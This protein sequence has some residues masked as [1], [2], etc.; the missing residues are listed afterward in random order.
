MPAKK[1]RSNGRATPSNGAADSAIARRRRDEVVTAATAIIAS[2]G[3]HRLSLARIEERT[4]MTRGHLTY[5]FP[6]KEAILLAV[7]DRMLARM[8][9]EAIADARRRGAP[10]PGTGAVWECLRHGLTRSLAPENTSRCDQLRA[11]VHTFMAQIPY[12]DDYQRKLACAHA[13]WRDHIAADYAAAKPP[14]GAVSPTVYASI[15]M[16]LI[17]GLSGQ[18]RVDPNAFDRAEAV[19]ACLRMLAPLLGRAPES[20]EADE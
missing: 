9:D 10:E 4:G 3:L 2:E 17:Q 8:I 7:F 6:T 13:G 1:A 11:L 5:Y 14:A 16:A 12:R 20:G 18:L 19:E 15:V